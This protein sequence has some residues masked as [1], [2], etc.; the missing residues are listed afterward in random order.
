MSG[1]VKSSN[2]SCLNVISYV[3]DE[4]KYTNA[5]SISLL[6]IGENLTLFQALIE[7]HYLSQKSESERKRWLRISLATCEAGLQ[8]PDTHIVYHDGLQ[9]RIKRL[10]KLLR[11][12]KKNQL[13]FSDVALKKP[14]QRVLPGI[15]GWPWSE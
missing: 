8:D 12:A 7:Q 10:E 1:S 3:A 6:H 13:Q 5:R 14:V 11:V 15:C 2:L 9:K 4:V